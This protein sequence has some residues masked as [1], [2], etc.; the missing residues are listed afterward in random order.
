[1]A[2]ILHID[3]TTDDASIGIS[4]KGSLLNEMRNSIQ[5]EHGSFLHIGIKE[6]CVKQQI[7]L[8]QLDA[9]AVVNGPGSYTGIRIGIATAKGL[10]Y[11]LQKP[12]I[13]LNTLH[14]MAYSAQ[15]KNTQ[16]WYCPMIDA[17]RMEV[18]YALYDDQLVPII[19]PTTLVL[20][21]QS[22]RKYLDSGAILFMGNGA[23]KWK[24]I[25]T[26]QNVIMGTMTHDISGVSA[27]AYAHF[28]QKKFADLRNVDACYAK[29][30]YDTRK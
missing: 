4:M 8:T 26:H 14:V 24:E 18:F 11:A 9:I 12:L 30:F 27:L 21:D 20:T 10:S 13:A 6:L 1:M 7:E 2:L 15:N 29:A 25:A 23:L 5:K 3:T 22:F 28:L 17:R 19:E 16:Q